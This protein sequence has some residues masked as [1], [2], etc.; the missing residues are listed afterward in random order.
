MERCL[1]GDGFVG[2]SHAAGECWGGGIIILYQQ[3][4]NVSRVGGT[5]LSALSG[6]DVNSIVSPTALHHHTLLLLQLALEMKLRYAF[7]SV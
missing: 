5:G 4:I 7:L 1:E 3:I 6:I 2:F